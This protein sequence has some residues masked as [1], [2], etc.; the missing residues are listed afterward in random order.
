MQPQLIEA[1]GHEDSNFEIDE[2]KVFLKRVAKYSAMTNDINTFTLELQTRLIKLCE[3][4]ELFAILIAEVKDKYNDNQSNFY[5]CKLGTT[6]IGPDSEK[7]PDPDFLSGVS[8][9][10]RENILC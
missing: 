6:Y 7:L 9:Y 3:C 8:K 4:R 2:T 1:S 5:Q 10:K